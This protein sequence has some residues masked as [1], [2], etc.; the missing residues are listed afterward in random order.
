MG[1]FQLF[2]SEDGGSFSHCE[3]SLHL[4]Q[5]VVVEG[6]VLNRIIHI[7]NI[8]HKVGKVKRLARPAG[9]FTFAGSG[10]KFV[11]MPLTFESDAYVVSN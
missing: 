9:L 4:L 7:A 2:A 1:C 3:S 5:N 11:L 10:I 6:P 8:I